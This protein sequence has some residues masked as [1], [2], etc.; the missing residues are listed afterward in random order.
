VISLK[1]EAPIEASRWALTR[2]GKDLSA[3]I[4][5]ILQSLASAG[6]LRVQRNMG[7][8]LGSGTGWLK[9]HIYGVRRSEKHYVVAAP[10][11]IAEPLERGATIRPKTG[12]MLFI[13]GKQGSVSSAVKEVTIP[14]RHWFTKSMA[15]FEESSE[16]TKAID[17]GLDRAIKRFGTAVW[18]KP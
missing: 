10:R 17:R 1:I 3:A 13:G 4:K 6:K 8:Y 9:K 11:H 7:A 14:A 18:G 2:L 16:Y 15:G 12:K 5:P